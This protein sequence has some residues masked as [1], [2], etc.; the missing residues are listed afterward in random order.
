MG[1]RGFHLTNEEPEALRSF[2]KQSQKM[3]GCQATP[4]DNSK[5]KIETPKPDHLDPAER[6]ELIKAIPTEFA[7][8]LESQPPITSERWYIS[9]SM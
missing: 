3:M 6:V 7:Q 2:H 8:V 1:G 5:A 4:E 9:Q